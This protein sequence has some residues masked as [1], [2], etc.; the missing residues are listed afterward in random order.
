MRAPGRLPEAEIQLSCVSAPQ[1]TSAVLVDIRQP[2]IPEAIW[3]ISFADVPPVRPIV[4]WFDPDVFDGFW[5][6]VRKQPLE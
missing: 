5:T 4:V 3:L 6:Y 1:I 2:L